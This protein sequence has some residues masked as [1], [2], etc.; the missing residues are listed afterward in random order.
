MNRPRDTLR[1][2][3]VF[4]P[5]TPVLPSSPAACL[6]AAYAESRQPTAHR[7]SVLLLLWTTGT[8]WICKWKESVSWSCG[9]SVCSGHC[10]MQPPV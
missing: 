7:Q 5:L 4:L 1:D 6:G 3:S 2:E 9:E 10:I 8:F